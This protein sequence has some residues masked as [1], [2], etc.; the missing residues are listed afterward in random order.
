MFQDAGGQN[1]QALQARLRDARQEISE[2]K[3]KNK[4]LENDAR[5]GGAAAGGAA[6]DDE[7]R[8]TYYSPYCI[9]HLSRRLSV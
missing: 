3:M 7:A 8:P 1:L 9:S 6:V 4:Q 5:R 2:L